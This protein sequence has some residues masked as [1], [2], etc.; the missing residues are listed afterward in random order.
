[1]TDPH[2]DLIAYFDPKEEKKYVRRSE[3]KLIL[4][5]MVDKGSFAETLMV[6]DDELR[7]DLEVMI[8]QRVQEEMGAFMLEL[9]KPK[10]GSLIITRD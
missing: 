6:F 5:Y 2:I 8:K 1:M 3:I 10:D 9:Q 7:K 4:A